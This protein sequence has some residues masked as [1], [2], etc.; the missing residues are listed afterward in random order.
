MQTVLFCGGLGTRLREETEF[1]P[2]PMVHIGNKPIIWHI[3]KIYAH[4]GYNEFVLTLGHKGDMIKDFFLHYETMNNDVTIE[5]GR[6]ESI[7]MHNCHDE[8]GWKITLSNTGEN[9]LKGGRLKRVEKY[10]RGDTFMLT[11]GDGVANVDINKLLEFHHSHGKM[12]TVTG[13]RPIARFGELLVDDQMVRSFQEKPQVSGDNGL[14][15]GGFFVFNRDIFDYLTE[16]ENCDLEH[17]PLE[18]LAQKHQLMAYRHEGFWYCM[19]T[20]RDMEKLNAMWD[21]GEAPWKVW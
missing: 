5:L 18:A 9:T 10:I 8:C 6:P 2:K 3:M 20:L 12:V 13:V 21:R 7:N 11:Y 14:I 17:G 1:K 15:S 16:D 4:F 19:D